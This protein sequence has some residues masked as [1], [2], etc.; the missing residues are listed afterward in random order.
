MIKL[1]TII[2]LISSLSAKSGKTGSDNINITAEEIR[3]HIQFLS[4][5]KLKGR[6]PGTAGYK[7]AV[8]YIEKNWKQS[9][10]LP[11]GNKHYKQLFEF[12]DGISISG[13]NRFK[14]N[15]TKQTFRVKKDYMPLGFSG[16][17]K[18]DASVVFVGYGFSVED[19]VSWND[20]KNINVKDRWVLV[21]RGSPDGSSPHS[22][23]A[24]YSAMRKKYIGARDN[25]AIG[26][27]FV[28]RFD[29]EDQNELTALH[30]SRSS[31]QDRIAALHISQEIAEQLLADGVSLKQLQ[32]S[33][34][35]NKTTASFETGFSVS[36]Q[37][38]LREKS[39]KGINVVGLLPGDGSTKELVVIGAHMDHL[40]FGGGESGSLKP[41]VHAIHNGADDN[42]SGVT[43]LLELAEKLGSIPGALKRGLLFIAFDAEEK[44][45]IGSKYFVNNPTVEF[46]NVT[47][48]VNMDMVG[49]MK[50][51]S[52]SVGGTGTSPLFEPLLD[53]LKIIHNL[54]L[55]YNRGGYGPSDH[56]SFYAK[57]SPVLFF[58]TGSHEDYHK[59]TD[60]WE[61]IN[62]EGEKQV[63]DLV[64]DVVVTLSNQEEKPLFTESGS[65]E[66]ASGRRS[67]KVSMG[68]IPSYTSSG[69]GF[70]IDG[71][72][73]D[74]PAANAG[75][76][77][78]D[79]I[80]EINGKE[81]R[82]IYDYMSRLGELKKGQEVS[83]LIQ[84]GDKLV[85]LLL[86]L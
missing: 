40:G 27:L 23:Y 74:G 75:M 66:R 14:I 36:T 35:D 5:D 49:R 59:P 80:L 38:G 1:I 42:A 54:K 78:G 64:Y 43:G 62:V 58:F 17:G 24:D 30:F 22:A 83:V 26:I 8:Q 53:S 20:Y 3:D 6:H 51:S 15:E 84:R 68:V 77:G 65:K 32:I 9:G 13:Y 44:G 45:L 52:L 2:L 50:E 18:T 79:A 55:S 11:A 60:D 37:I 25:G 31:N 33:I 34:D 16:T 73:P 67:F 56:S 19:S 81:V 4:S 28:N 48:M 21:F 7:K 10:L 82:D 69:R 46:D 47:A 63:L 39:V 86:K 61:K 57:K 12:A 76:V 41:D 72:R 85:S 29:D 70:A 71:V